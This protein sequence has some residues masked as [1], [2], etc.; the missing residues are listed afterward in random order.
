MQYQ[1]Q[2]VILQVVVVEPKLTVLL[3]IWYNNNRKY[4]T[5]LLK[6]FLNELNLF[7]KGVYN[8]LFQLLY[9]LKSI[10]YL[11]TL[12]LCGTLKP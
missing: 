8:I 1:L 11:S 7:Y 5:L 12:T 3:T 2:Q 6:F 9:V 10:L 4:Q